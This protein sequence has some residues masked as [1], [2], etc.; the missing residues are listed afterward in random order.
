MPLPVLG[1]SYL[2]YVSNLQYWFTY[3]WSHTKYINW[4]TWIDF[5]TQLEISLCILIFIFTTALTAALICILFFDLHVCLLLCPFLI[6][7]KAK[8]LYIYI[9]FDL[10][11][12]LLWCPFRMKSKTKSLI[13][14]RAKFKWILLI[15]NKNT[16]IIFEI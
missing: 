8:T 16:E 15:Q 10:H 2:N 1:I 9:F 12:C 5:R 7:S 11:V 6:K 13:L 14:I 3:I 4:K